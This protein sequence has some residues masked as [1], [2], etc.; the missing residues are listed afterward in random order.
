MISKLTGIV[1]E[2]SGAA[3]TID[4]SGVGYLVNCSRN[5]VQNLEEG[6]EAKLVIHTD[7]R[8]DAI[9]L[10]GFEDQ[11]ERKVFS[12]LT[13]VKGVGTKSALEI[14]SRIEKRQLLRTI[15]A[16]DWHD[17]QT[18]KGIG[19][20]TAERIIV[21]LKDKVAEFALESS[22]L[23]RE[24]EVEMVEPVRDALEA[25][26]ALG[27]PRKDAEGAVGK[28]QAEKLPGGIDS[29]EIVKR[30]LRYV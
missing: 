13:K 12:L 8:E 29:G 25:L 9:Q 4:V 19:R 6:A 7:V 26:V 23:R 28:V 11:L 22:S 14:I 27:F 17:L 24:I 3:V 18:V 5:L 20:K 15:G 30:A 2:I 21:E 10:Y 1:D 16:G